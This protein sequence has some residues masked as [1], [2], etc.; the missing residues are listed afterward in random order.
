VTPAKKR[1]SYRVVVGRYERKRLL[2]R[3]R[4]KSEDN[5]KIDFKRIRWRRLD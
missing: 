1:K 3:P 4:R 2:S 5:I